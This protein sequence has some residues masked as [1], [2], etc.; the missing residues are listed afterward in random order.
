MSIHIK[1]D[2]MHLAFPIKNRA[3]EFELWYFDASL[4]NGDYLVVMYSINDTRLNPSQPSV[5]TNIYEQNGNQI[6]EVRKYQESEV[7]VSYERCDVKMGEEYCVDRGGSY[8]FHANM[9]GNGAH[10]VFYPLHPSWSRPASRSIMGWTVAIPYG[11]VEGVLMKSGKKL[12]V[13][14]TGYH[15][16]NWGTRPMGA[17]FRNWY[18]GKV[19][20]QDISVAYG[21][22]IPRIGKK[23]FTGIL[24]TDE[25]GIILEPKMAT[26]L[27]RVKTRLNKMEREP[28]LGYHIANQLVMNVKEKGFEMKLTIDIDRLLMKD[29]RSLIQSESFYRYIGNAKLVVKRGGAEREYQT[30]SLHEIV[31][32]PDPT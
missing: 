7:N 8:E 19:H 11:T 22:M 24:V 5:R 27:F 21:I 17:I 30:T 13:K 14:G 6:R 3:D 18:W 32:L 28:S 9:N 29:V 12:P 20:T 25:Y 4:D 2:A 23:P 15:D 1:D 16:H 26:S 10:L 31:F